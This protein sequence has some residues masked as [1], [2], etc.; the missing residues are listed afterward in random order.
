MSDNYGETWRKVLERVRDAAWD[1]LIALPEV[2]DHRIVASHLHENGSVLVSHSD[3]FYR[4]LSPLRWN[5][6]GFYQTKEY[7]FTLID[8][9]EFSKGY[10]LEVT[11]SGRS[12]LTEIVLPIEDKQS[13][14]CS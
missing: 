11:K 10:D 12:N 14:P 8:A 1:K 3:D 13:T 2:P 4:T 6:Y 7:L 9:D 5:G